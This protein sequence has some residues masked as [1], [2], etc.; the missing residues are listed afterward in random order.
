LHEAKKQMRTALCILALALVASPAAP[1]QQ[2]VPLHSRV[3]DALKRMESKDASAREAAYD[4]LSSIC[5]E[6]ANAAPH[7][8]AS[9]IKAYG[10]TLT[11]FFVLY[12]EEAD[13]VKIGFIR[14]L[15]RENNASE[16]GQQGTHTESYGEYVFDLTQQVSALH[17]ERTIPVLV[18]SITRSGVDL[19][20]FGDEALEPVLAQLKN[21]DALVR[22]TTLE[23]ALGI[24]KEKNDAASRD[25]IRALILSSLEDRSLVVRS[26]AVDSIDCLEGRQEFVPT[27]EKIAKTDPDK[28]SRKAK[29][30]DGGDGNELY[31][32][33]YAARRVLRD[34]QNNTTC[35]H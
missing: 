7:G 33:R 25:R 24:L 14:L 35:Q 1:A 4:D 30:L 17:D 22:A 34:I 3:T 18:E 15:R 28:F 12:P 20:Q 11:A 8:A 29:A 16:T 21:P 32:V 5:A 31:P 10:N 27:L 26:A 6:G 9:P 19:L 13:R 2:T 23:T